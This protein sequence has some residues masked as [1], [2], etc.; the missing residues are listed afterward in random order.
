VKATNVGVTTTYIG[1]PSLSSGQ[2]YFE[3]TGSTSNMKNY[4]YAGSTRVAM[5]TG[6]STLNYLL[7]DH[8]GST[9][10]TANSSGV[11]SAELRY[12]PWGTERYNSGTTPTTYHFTGQ[13]LESTIGLYYYG[14]RWYDPA[15]ARFVQADSVVPIQNANSNYARQIQLSLI[16]DYHETNLLIQLNKIYHDNLL[17]NNDTIGDQSGEMNQPT[18]KSA[19]TNTLKI[20]EQDNN[21]NTDTS[22]QTL[23]DFNKLSNHGKMPET[24]GQYNQNQRSDERNHLNIMPLQLNS[25]SLDRYAYTLNC[26][27]K[28]TDPSGHCD[29]SKA[30]G[31]G[32]IVLLG[33]G[34]FGVGVA[35][36][37]IGLIEVTAAS[38]T[39]VGIFIGFHE[40]GVGGLMAG[41]GVL[42]VEKG[43]EAIIDSD[44]LTKT[45]SDTPK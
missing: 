20:N 39:I 1:N 7:G 23:I 40:M 21:I 11:K 34:I 36:F 8:L 17:R 28:Y 38:P 10:I 15:A 14:A 44:C 13:R 6:S 43:V 2:G 25:I 42:V 35:F 30:L 24:N 4:Y 12:Y 33:G 45:E 29:V 22:N 5:R 41:A 19:N 9:A 16:V 31:G 3:W 37:G 27:T 18:A 26:P 32:A